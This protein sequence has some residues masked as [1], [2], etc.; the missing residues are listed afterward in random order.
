L[1]WK[2]V[3]NLRGMVGGIRRRFRGEGRLRSRALLKATK[4]E[5]G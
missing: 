3:G 4:P 5:E 1:E 2:G